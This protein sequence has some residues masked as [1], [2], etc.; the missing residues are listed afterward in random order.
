MTKPKLLLI[1]GISPFPQISG[2]ATRIK[3]TILYLSKKY[4]IYFYF[5]IEK[6]FVIKKEDSNFLIKHAVY[7][8][9]IECESKS[10]INSFK[11]GI[12]YHFSNYFSNSLIAKLAEIEKKINFDEVRIESTQ[13]LYLQRYLQDYVYIKFVALDVSVVSFWRRAFETFNP[14][15]V[16]I[17]LVSVVQIYLY[18]K[19]YLK[20]FREILVMSKI[21][22]SYV[23]KIYGIK[24]IKISQ[25]GI[26]NIN[27]LPKKTDNMLTIGFIGSSS[28]SPNR[29]AIKFILNKI[30]PRFIE[31]KINF[32]AIILGKNN[33]ENF[34]AKNNYNV[35]F[36]NHV[37]NLKDFYSQ[38]DILVAPIFSGSGTRVKILESLS[39]GRP[40]ITTTVGAEGIEI[41]SKFLFIVPKN[42]QKEDEYWIDNI[43]YIYENLDRLSVDPSNLRMKLSKLLWNKIIT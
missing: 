24:N 25:N 39:Y 15:F 17:R 3:Q 7:F 31:R 21:D 40:V 18:E 1:S 14:L 5:F 27:F 38:I 19:K 13:L 28:H 6:N 41:N 2:G 9:P 12:P 42:K 26:D 10:V 8:E 35:E 33:E 16:F 29:I 20:F 32:K 4:N 23:E 34:I 30:N 43:I 37:E 22:A 36:I 11:T